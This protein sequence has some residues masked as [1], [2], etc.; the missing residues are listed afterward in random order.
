MWGRGE[1]PSPFLMEKLM[2]RGWIN[3]PSKY[4][5]NNFIQIK[6][7]SAVSTESKNDAITTVIYIVGDSEGIPTT[8]SVAE[9]MALIAEAS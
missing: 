8:A 1:T 5:R 4:V 6:H 9:V 7:I 3:P 2:L